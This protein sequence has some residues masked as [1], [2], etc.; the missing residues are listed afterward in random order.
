MPSLVG[1]EMCIRD[2]QSGVNSYLNNI[3]SGGSLIFRNGTGG[4]ERMRL[5]GD[6]LMV[7]T[8]Q[9]DVGYTD[10]GAGASIDQSG[11]IQSA[12]SS[13]NANLYLNKLDNDGEIINLRRDGITFGSVGS[14][15]G[16]ERLYVV[17]DSTGLS[18]VGDF[19]KILPCDSAGAPRDAA[20]DL[21]QGSGG[22]FKDLYL[23]SGV[24]LGGT[25][26]ANKLDD[27]EEGTHATSISFSISGSVTTSS[28]TLLYTKIGQLVTVTGYIAING[29]S[30]PRGIMRFT[31]PFAVSYG[32]NLRASANVKFN[33]LLSGENMTTAAWAIVEQN[34]NTVAIYGGSGHGVDTGTGARL[35]TNTDMRVSMSYV[36]SA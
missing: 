28:N 11:V 21:G 12:R 20:I 25:G 3:A 31:L 17:N 10:S 7:G 33:Q 36:T 18:F 13:A 35:A 29:T 23:S 8:S 16:G 4:T 9:T 24:F 6:N 2:R 15:N 26:A 30:S 22:R 32:A 19:S 1:S 5:S 14:S 27:Y 34:T